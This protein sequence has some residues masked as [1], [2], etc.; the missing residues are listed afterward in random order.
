MVDSQY[1]TDNY[2]SVKI[3]IGAIIRSPEMLRLVHNYLKTKKMCKHSAKK[4]SFLKRYV[5]DRYKAQEML[6]HG[7]SL[8]FVPNCY[9]KQNV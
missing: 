5:P 7:E 2:N 3:V 8:K 9:S 4:L 1:S 6:E